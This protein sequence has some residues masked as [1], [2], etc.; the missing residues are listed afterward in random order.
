MKTRRLIR[1]VIPL[2]IAVVIILVAQRTE[3]GIVMLQQCAPFLLPSSQLARNLDCTD[4]DVVRE[5]LGILADRRN[6]IAADRAV[7]LLKSPDDYV[8][9]NSANYLG[10]LGREEAVP[11]L[12]KGLRH[13]ASRSDGE[14]V[15]DLQH[16]TGQ[17]FGTNFVAWSNWWA[18][19][20]ST[21]AFDFDSKLGPMPRKKW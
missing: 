12:I 8:W 10:G 3:F 6:P 20:H 5:S 1:L 11:Y 19:A 14:R 17:S 18:Q 2:A 21:A 7:V 16:I 13:T 9:L 15:T 4:T